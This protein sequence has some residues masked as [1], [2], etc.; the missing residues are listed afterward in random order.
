MYGR[1][2]SSAASAF[3]R[4]SGF[5]LC[6]SR[7]RVLRVMETICVGLSRNATPHWLSFL[8]FSG[9]NSSCQDWVTSV[10]PKMAL[11]LSA[12]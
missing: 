3:F 4:S 2:A 5:W 12:L 7:P 11:I 9:L 10:L 1:M 8:M 6:G